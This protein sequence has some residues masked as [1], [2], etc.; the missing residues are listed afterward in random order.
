MNQSVGVWAKGYDPESL[1]EI[2]DLW[3]RNAQSRHAFFPWTGEL[4]AR[5]LA[6]KGTPY[7]VI[8]EAREDDVLAGF[9]HMAVVDESGYPRAGTIEAILVDE[10]YRNRGLGTALLAGAM[11]SFRNAPMRPEFI[12]ALGAW[13]FGYAFNVLA[14]GSERSGVFVRDEP[15]Y[16]LFRRAGFEPARKSFVMRADVA[17]PKAAPRPLPGRA[18]FYIARRSE[19]TWLDRVFRGRELWDHDLVQDD[20]RLLSRAIF[21]LME[22]ESRREGTIIFSVFGVNTPSDMRGKGY[23]TVNV[24][25]MMHH[26]SG[27]GAD[28]VELHV[29]GDNQPALNLYRALGF[30]PEAETMMMH[31]NWLR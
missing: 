3:N 14:D 24:S 1:G 27:L 2:A 11:A 10:R 7:G 12:D 28:K 17:G 31:C 15:L 8:L 26:L 23:A 4:L 29:Y 20:G 19:R 22:G 9:A 18:R 6:E 16:R 30:E 25:H 13:P 21:G 5:R